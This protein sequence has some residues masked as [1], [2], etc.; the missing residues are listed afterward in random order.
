MQQ[1][2]YLVL[3]PGNRLPHHCTLF[4]Y[5]T[6][7][8]CLSFILVTSAFLP[9]WGF[10]QHHVWV[11]G[12]SII[13]LL[14]FASLVQLMLTGESPQRGH[15][16]SQAL[17]SSVTFHPLLRKCQ[18]FL[19]LVLNP[20]KAMPQSPVLSGRVG[21]RW[22][23]CVGCPLWGKPWTSPTSGPQMT[24]SKWGRGAAKGPPPPRWLCTPFSRAKDSLFPGAE[25][26]CLGPASPL[27]PLGTCL[28]PHKP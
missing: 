18:V 26:S 6:R 1:L 19:L 8:T 10:L 17:Q 25:S 13:S 4:L 16:A 9:P 2:Q 27:V 28:W 15:E 14:A 23:D 21:S 22:A 7:L 24:C 5:W 20:W 3:N 11:P 12:V